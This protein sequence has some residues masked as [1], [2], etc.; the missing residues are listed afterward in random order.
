ME[1]ESDIHL[2]L[3]VIIVICLIVIAMSSY[4]SAY[5]SSYMSNS[6]Y[7]SDPNSASGKANIRFA[8]E[9]SQQGLVPSSGFIGS[10][11]NE[12]PVFYN[13]GSFEDVNKALQ[14]V[15]SVKENLVGTYGVKVTPDGGYKAPPP[16]PPTPKASV[17]NV[18]TKS[19]QSSHFTVSGIDRLEHFAGQG[20]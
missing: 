19:R 15:V 10:G 18:P 8:G 13:T 5:C 2:A 17:G 20:Y 11:I 14:K 12:P 1:S 9:S 6:D 4:Q 3:F 16:P 7:V